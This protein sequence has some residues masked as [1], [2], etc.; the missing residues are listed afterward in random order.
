MLIQAKLLET[1]KAQPD[2]IAD[3]DRWLF[4]RAKRGSYIFYAG[5]LDLYPAGA[6]FITRA[7][8]T[9][10]VNA[11]KYPNHRAGSMYAE[12]LLYALGVTTGMFDHR[13]GQNDQ[14]YAQH[15]IMHSWSQIR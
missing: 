8:T 14:Y 3:P 13:E 4:C 9:Y 2:G 5:L 10:D 11:I 7:G 12:V 15:D 1:F 6:S